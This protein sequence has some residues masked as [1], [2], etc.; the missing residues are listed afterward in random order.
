MRKKEELGQRKKR[1]GIFL[2][3]ILGLLIIL[4]FYFLIINYAGLNKLIDIFSGKKAALGS[5]VLETIGKEALVEMPSSALWSRIVNFRPGDGELADINPPRFSWTYDPNPKDVRQYG[6]Y[7]YF[8]FQVSNSNDFDSPH[9]VVN[10]S[11][12]TNMYNFLSP[13]NVDSAMTYFWRVGYYS[14]NNDG[15]RTFDQWSNVRNFSISSDAEVWDRSLLANEAYLRQKATHPYLVFNESVKELLKTYL[16]GKERIYLSN[17]YSNR[18]DY[19]V[20]R[21]WSNIKGLTFPELEKPWWYL[22]GHWNFDSLDSSWKR[23]PEHDSF[24]GY[25][26]NIIGNIDFNSSGSSGQGAYFLGGYLQFNL[27]LPLLQNFSLLVSAKFSVNSKGNM[28]LWSDG[29]G[30]AFAVDPANGI[31]I[32]NQAEICF[33]HKTFSDGYWHGFGFVKNATLVSVYAD[34]VLIGNCGI[35]AGQVNFALSTMGKEAGG[36]ASLNA[37]LDEIYLF[38]R[39]LTSGE[40]AGSNFATSEYERGLWFS[41]ALFIYRLTGDS[42]FKVDKPEDQGS[43]QKVYERI[44]RFYLDSGGVEMWRTDLISRQSLAS[45]SP[46]MAL[47]Y[48]GLYYNLSEGQR[49]LALYAIELNS[50][51]FVNFAER[52]GWRFPYVGCSQCDSA[53]SYDNFN[54]W[55]SAPLNYT[56]PYV[57][58]SGSVTKA[59]HSHFQDDFPVSLFMAMAAYNES[60]QVREFFDLGMNYLIG[61]TNSFGADGG[62]NN[63]IE[64]SSGHLSSALMGSIYAQES[65]P[66]VQFNKNLH[67][68]KNAE[69]LDRMIPVGFGERFGMW[70]DTE[71]GRVTVLTPH[72]NLARNLGYFIGDGSLITHWKN[73]YSLWFYDSFIFGFY[74]LPISYF[75][76][77]PAPTNRSSNAQIFDNGW[78][79]GCSGNVNDM[80]C[81]RNGTGF[82]F[83]ARPS[84]STGG[85]DH[86]SDLSY[87]IWAYGAVLTQPSGDSSYSA[88]SESPYSK[89]SVLVNGL[90]N[91]NALY[92]TDPYA[93]RIFA[94]KETKDYVYAAA[95]G[96]N[97]YPRKNFYPQG[98]LMGGM[99]QF[100]T[101]HSGAPLADLKKVHRHLLLVHNKYYIIYDDLESDANSVFTW[102][103]NVVDSDVSLISSPEL[104]INYV[105]NN[106]YSSDILRYPGGF[107]SVKVPVQVV[108]M[109]NASDLNISDLRGTEGAKNLIT[110][111]DYS[112][113]VGFSPNAHSYWV[114]NKESQKKFHFMTVI[115]PQK[116]G[117]AA[118][119]IQRLDD[120]TVNV[121]DEDGSEIISFDASTTWSADLIIN[122]S[123]VTPLPVHDFF[124]DTGSNCGDRVING[125][126]VCDGNSRECIVSGGYLGAQTCNGQCSEW[127]TCI[128]T[129]RCGDS[130]VNGNEQC[131]DGN[132]INGDRCLN[133]CTFNVTSLCLDR[134]RDGVDDYDAASC[135]MGRDFCVELNPSW[136]SL[137]P[138]FNGNISFDL[139][140]DFLNMSDF[141]MAIAGRGEIVFKQGVR[142]VDLNET[143]CFRK[144]N[145][146]DIVLFSDKKIFVNSTRFPEFAKAARLTFEDIS[147]VQ[148][149]VYRDNVECILC[150]ITNYNLI[151]KN[152]R[153]DVPGF[154][155]YEVREEYVSSGNQGGNSEGGGGSGGSGGSGNIGKVSSVGNLM[156]ESYGVEGVVLV[157]NSQ[158]GQQEQIVGGQGKGNGGLG[159]IFAVSIILAILIVILIA[160]IVL[161][162]VIRNRQEREEL[163]ESRLK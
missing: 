63:G 121:T 42:R 163:Y 158:A 3:V 56:G 109:N 28:T 112:A 156:N 129:Q 110:G 114:S 47:G 162:R 78:V 99:Q 9:L 48:D 120:Y 15:S 71:A 72:R 142:I 137:I 62:L 123:D 74:D 49:K 101:L 30:I 150:N 161:I 23:Y 79:V 122:L 91:V 11:T 55:W 27:E 108:Q 89:L 131:D 25:N 154:S 102:R 66:E 96:T 133:N 118:A 35:K 4:L 98:W 37:T 18:N 73:E 57:V 75:F 61:V 155:E 146:T 94:Y 153:V 103:Y 12:N 130:I 81:F 159:T 88:W 60:L 31:Y 32:K 117:T 6:Q 95:D 107:D 7:R 2:F 143:G 20:G 85:H 113:V 59:G 17:N 104:R 70:A 39:A 80:S 29:E 68:K 151:G 93:A 5:P 8:L 40:I 86:Y 51:Y 115:Y 106:S 69:W 33:L 127:N 22:I 139:T 53:N 13:F 87:Q 97:A 111:E 16:D 140:G 36:F 1:K 92:Q 105:V 21:G 132:L 148:P 44:V 83:E 10:V 50:N 134:D 160:V 14:V 136:N 90:G 46:A 100:N 141:K 77:E 84:G 152:L 76:N 26:F 126:E 54:K 119:K 125:S 52:T 147:F 24:S 144:L 38:G 19:D 128:A 135:A 124:T 138:D 43:L 58:V 157:N 64:Y 82:I 34:N 45:F 145:L 41:N 149:K 65:F 67:F 116:P